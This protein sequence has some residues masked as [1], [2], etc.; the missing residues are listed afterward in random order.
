MSVSIILEDKLQASMDMLVQSGE[1][2][3]HAEIVAKGV[4]LIEAR[5]LRLKAFD[6]AVAQGWEDSQNG[7]VVDLDI[8][9]DAL[10]AK[11][12]AKAAAQAA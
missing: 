5:Q 11:W 7:D 6:E 1:F 3:S 12:E 8:A 10:E 4:A 2:K 9:F